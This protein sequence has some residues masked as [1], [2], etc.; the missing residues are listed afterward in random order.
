MLPSF[1]VVSVKGSFSIFVGKLKNSWNDGIFLKISF[2]SGKALSYV[3]CGR[4]IFCCGKL[5]D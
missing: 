3:E 2:D 1:I 4:K 5:S